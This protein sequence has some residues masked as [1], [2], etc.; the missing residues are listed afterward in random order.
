M[1]AIKLLKVVN[2]DRTLLVELPDDTPLGLAEISISVKPVDREVQATSE[3]LSE[4]ESIRAKLRA[5]HFLVEIQEPSNEVPVIEDADLP[6]LGR[7][8][9]SAHSTEDLLNE[10]RGPH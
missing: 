6:E 9:P 4:R 7:L 8:P 2:P 3:A 5:A 1:T 10:D